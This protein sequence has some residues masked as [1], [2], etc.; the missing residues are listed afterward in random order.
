M[1]RRLNFSLIQNNR[2]TKAELLY[3]EY[4]I[5]NS[6]GNEPLV[7]WPSSISVAKLKLAPSRSPPQGTTADTACFK[8]V[9]LFSHHPGTFSMPSPQAFP[10]LF[11]ARLPEMID[12]PFQ[13]K[14]VPYLPIKL[15]VDLTPGVLVFLLVS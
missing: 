2:Y 10:H 11:L 4:S 5:G 7:L 3:W 14:S 1:A 6:I 15:L 8:P 13:T 9:L 12:C